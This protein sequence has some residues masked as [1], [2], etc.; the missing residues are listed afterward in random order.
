MG[1][2]R[3]TNGRGGGIE[4]RGGDDEAGLRLELDALHPDDAAGEFKDGPKGTGR[5]GNFKP[6]KD[7]FDFARA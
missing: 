5:T 6:F 7:F 3:R 4:R 2:G 1:S